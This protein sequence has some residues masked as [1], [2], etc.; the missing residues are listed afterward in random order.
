M[1]AYNDD[2][3]QRLKLPGLKVNCLDIRSET[4]KYDLTLF[5]LKTG[6]EITG[7]YEY[8]SDIFTR[9]TI[10]RFSKHFN[11]LTEFVINNTR[12]PIKTVPLLT[13]KERH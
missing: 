13:E 10:C 7:A 4:A 1:Y 3:R 9:D 6:E 5:I 8:N 12:K 2:A 11:V